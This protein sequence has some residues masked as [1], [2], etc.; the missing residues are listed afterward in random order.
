MYFPATWSLRV[1]IIEQ[2]LTRA[3][4]CQN[5]KTCLSWFRHPQLQ[6]SPALRTIFLRSF[7]ITAFFVCLFI[8]LVCRDWL[9]VEVTF[10]RI[11]LG[12]EFRYSGLIVWFSSHLLCDFHNLRIKNSDHEHWFALKREGEN[13]VGCYLH[14]MEQA[15]IKHS[16]GIPCLSAFTKSV[17]KI[18]LNIKVIT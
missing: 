14:A 1:D 5:N 12:S 18:L 17:R 15:S 9:R 3:S 7:N 4:D 6:G 13:V 2:A 8:G 11:Q 16:N 10:R